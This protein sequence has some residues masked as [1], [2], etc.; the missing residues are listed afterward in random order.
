MNFAITKKIGMTRVFNQDGKN[1]AVTLLECCKGVISR[2]KIRDS[3]DGYNAVVVKIESNKKS[4]A[5]KFFEFRV[6]DTSKFKVGESVDLSSFSENSS[7]NAES[8]TKGKG[9]AGTIKRH[10]FHRG[11]VTHGSHNIRKPGSI[12]GGYPQRVVLGRKMPG[13]MGNKN[14]TQKNLKV[15]DVDAK[16]NIISIAGSIPGPKKSIVKI[17]SEK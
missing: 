5:D 14:S 13:R 1:I 12:G 4:Q 3:K 16:N 10:G 7:V 17:C 2:I 8:K 11:P 9:F 6:N 15:I